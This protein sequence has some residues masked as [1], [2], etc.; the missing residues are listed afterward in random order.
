MN[1]SFQGTT[2]AGKD[3]WLTPPAIIKALGSFDLDPCAPVTRPW[4]TAANHYTVEDDGLKQPWFG[5]VFCNPPYGN[6]AGKFLAK[7]ADHGNA[8]GLVFARLE[9]NWFFQNVWDRADAIFFIKGRLS[10]HHVTGEKGGPAGCGSVLLAYGQN[11][12]ELLHAVNIPGKFIPLK[13]LAAADL[14]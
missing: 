5:R 12:V 3:E 9:T 1:T 10:F 4:N 2:F 6:T 11:N 14:L 7:C 13:Y 8:I